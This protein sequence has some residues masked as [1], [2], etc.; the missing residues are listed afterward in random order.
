MNGLVRK[1]LDWTDDK[2]DEIDVTNDKHPYL[3]AFGCGAIE[4]L[5]DGAV[6]WFPIALGAAYYWK[7]KATKD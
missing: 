2:F 3:K 4:G 1:V 5:I 7:H 6:V